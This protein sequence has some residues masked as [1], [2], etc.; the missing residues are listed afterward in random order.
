MKKV[1][2]ITS[3]FLLIIII[4]NLILLFYFKNRHIQFQKELLFNQTQIC[5]NYIEKTISNYENDL[6]RIIF[7]NNENLHLIFSDAK[8]TNSILTELQKFYAKYRY[9]LSNIGIFDNS[10][11][12]LGI[13]I[14]DN[15]EFVIDTFSRQRENI[16]KERDTIEEKNGKYLSYFPFYKDNQLV[17]NVVAEINLHKYLNTIFKLY[18]YKG[19]QWQWI[20]NSNSEILLSTESDYSEINLLDSLASEIINENEGVVIQELNDPENGIRKIISSYYPLSVL[21]NDLSLIFSINIDKYISPFSGKYQ[22]LIVINLLLFSILFA[23]GSWLFYREIDKNETLAVNL[24][25]QKMIIEHF[26]VGILIMDKNGIITNINLTAQKML[27]LETTHDIVGKSFSD[28]FLVSNKYILG[29]N[30]NLPLDYNH[31]LIYEKDGNEIVIYRKEIKTFIAGEELTIS[32]LIDVSPFEKSRKQEIA[33]NMAKSDFLAKM[34]HEIRTPMNGIIGMTDN[35]LQSQLPEDQKEQ[36][37]IIKRSSALLMN[38]IND[39][40][41]FSKIEAGKMMLEEI[42][43]NLNDE[44]NLSIELYK[45]LA[46]EKNIELKINV[47]PDVP[48]S[49]IGDPFRLRQVLNN[50]LSNAIKFTENGI[51]LITADIVDKHNG[52][53]IL[54]F[55]VEDTGIGISK[56]NINK[57]FSTYEQINSSTSRI[58]GGTGLGTSIARQLVEM[59]NGEIWVES[60]GTLSKNPEFP[61]SKFSFTI[62]SFSNEKLIKK[63]DFSKI[64]HYQQISALIL[65]KIRDENDRIHSTLDSFG[66]NYNFMLFED[67]NIEDVIMHIETKRNIYQIIVIKDK[68]QHDGFTLAKKLKDKKLT[69]HFLIIMIS[70]NDRHGNY[71]RTRNLGIDNYLIQP[72][73][74]NEIFKILQN[75]FKEIPEKK[76]VESQI[77]QIRPELKILVADDNIINQRIIQTVFKHLGYEIDIAVNGIEAL[78]MTKKHKYDII[79]MDLIMPEMDGITTSFEIRKYDPSIPIIALSAADDKNSVDE[80]FKAGMN[81]YI[82]KPVKVENIKKVLIKRFS[83]TV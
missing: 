26:P 22:F 8:T 75:N 49:L 27:F 61:G 9:L 78:K 1:I 69:D 57:I 83:E 32:V 29:D 14:K 34:S 10:V 6:N 51:V 70:S 42:P 71:L 17:G 37:K 21:T 40:L 44:I 20:L 23:I 80:A 31:F 41:D 55:S 53:L 3:A 52:A 73:E 16:L 58:Y 15:D 4:I 63:F 74:S 30:I 7:Q 66:I 77:S 2:Y 54:L 64:T 18:S 79:F 24:L 60:P 65:S 59:M 62:E 72:Y 68:P 28:H 25:S 13:Y 35:L 67:N 46:E 76:S 43:F 81:D 50:L 12:Y 11:H 48:L 39:I 33:A 45:S 36:V 38:V 19:L 47:N 82:V 56:E 5:G